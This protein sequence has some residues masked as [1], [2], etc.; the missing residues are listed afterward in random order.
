MEFTLEDV[1]FD[2]SIVEETE[3]NDKFSNSHNFTEND[4]VYH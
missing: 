3:D 4:T 2:R 1:S